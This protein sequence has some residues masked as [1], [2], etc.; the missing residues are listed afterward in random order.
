MNEWNWQT[1]TGLMLLFGVTWALILCAVFYVRQLRADLI[2]YKDEVNALHE[3]L[4]DHGLR[5]AHAI[6]LFES[7]LNESDLNDK[8]AEKKKQLANPSTQLKDFL[9]DF[10]QH[11]CSFLRVS[12]DSVLLRSLR[13]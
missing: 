12:P 2:F 6:D 13:S 9:A 11:G 3:K 4:E 1:I 10:E 5:V 7:L 8:I